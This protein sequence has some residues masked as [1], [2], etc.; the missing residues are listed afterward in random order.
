MAPKKR[1]II[2]GGT[3]SPPHIGHINVANEIA[4][5]ENPDKLLIIPTWI[6][7]HKENDHIVDA[8]HRLEMCRLAFSGIQCAEISDIEIA[9]QGKSYTYLTLSELQKDDVELFFVCGTDMILSFDRWYRFRD[10]FNM[11]TI[12][13]VRRECD[14]EISVEIERKIKEYVDL[15]EARVRELKI[16]VIEISSSELRKKLSESLDVEQYI[17]PS[18]KKYIDE[19]NLYKHEG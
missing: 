17:S 8:H 16:D 11:A 3:F 7:P 12:I 6:S 5:V 15:H 13:Y 9:R 14:A 18:V 19:W 4:K 10:I 1:I 2:Y